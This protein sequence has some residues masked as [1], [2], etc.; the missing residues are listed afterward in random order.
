MG[1]SYTSSVS[2]VPDDDDVVF[3][4]DVPRFTDID[5]GYIEDPINAYNELQ[6]L[7]LR[8][9]RLRARQPTDWPFD[10]QDRMG[11]TFPGPGTYQD[12]QEQNFVP[13]SGSPRH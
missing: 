11:A 4:R 1:R 10:P 8:H 12:W 9:E 5:G 6:Q 13:Y 2:E 7:G 3:V